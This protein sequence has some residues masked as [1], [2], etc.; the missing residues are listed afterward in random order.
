MSKSGEILNRFFQAIKAFGS[1]IGFITFNHAAPLTG[2]HG[3]R[4]AVGQQIDKHVIRMNIE[5]II[6]GFL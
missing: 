2:A 3:R 1:G 5:K 4:T 6:A